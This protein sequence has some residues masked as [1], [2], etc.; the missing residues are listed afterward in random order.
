MAA[1]YSPLAATALGYGGALGGSDPLANESEEERRRRLLAA[2]AAKLLP[3]S[4]AGGMSPLAQIALG[5]GT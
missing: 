4:G 1:G 2:N 5:G 3:Q